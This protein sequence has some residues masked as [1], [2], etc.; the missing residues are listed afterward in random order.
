MRYEFRCPSCATRY[1][2]KEDWAGK[3]TKCRNCGTEIEIPFPPLELPDE[4]TTGGSVVYRHEQGMRD[5]ELALGDS[6]NIEAISNHIERW[7]GPVDNVY[8]EMMSDLVHIDLHIVNPTEA[9]PFY[10][11]VTSGMS[12]RKMHPP[13][14]FHD[15]GYAELLVNL[16]PDW[17]L[18]QKDL[19]DPQN[20]WPIR[21][22]KWLARFPHEYETWIFEGHTIPNGHPP[23]PIAENVDFCCF[24]LFRSVINPPEFS[25]L[26]IDDEKTIYFFSLYPL[27]EG[28]MNLKLEQGTDALL[29]RFEKHDVDDFIDPCR[30]DVSL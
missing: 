21:A 23:E 28:E 27:Y 13:E 25:E 30:V 2:A 14:D 12:D 16:P 15:L 1:Q 24:L 7:L 19:N 8:H 11:I 22:L 20:Y 29:E 10:S 9:R 6:E 5:F 3:K 4:V 17:P 18:N 26:K